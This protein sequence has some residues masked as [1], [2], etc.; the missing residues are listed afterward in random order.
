MKTRIS[1]SIAGLCAAAALAGSLAIASA[2]PPQPGFYVDGTLYRTVGTP[3][4]FSQTGAP[5]HSFDTIY[6]ISLSDSA[7]DP[8][9]VAEAAPGDRDF[10]G[11]RWMVHGITL[12]EAGLVAALDDDDVDQNGNNVL[13]SA[14]EVEAAIDLGYATDHGIVKM[15][16]CP[17]IKM[18]RGK[19]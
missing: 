7:V 14:E 2:A 9:N 8:I 17:V 16:E 5:D 1:L 18:P 13:D 15:F 11:G 19:S 12:T 10:N 6:D 4:D 3:T